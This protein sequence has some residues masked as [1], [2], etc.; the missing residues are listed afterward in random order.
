MKGCSPGEMT[1]YTLG[2]CMAF[3]Q[4]EC[5]HVLPGGSSGQM[6]RYTLGISMAFPQSVSA[7][8]L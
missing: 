3:Y 2:I 8:V 4:S 7:H 6:I 1:C 5:A